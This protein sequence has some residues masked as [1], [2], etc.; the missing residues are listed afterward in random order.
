MFQVDGNFHEILETKKLTEKA[1]R[2]TAIK[3]AF[4]AP[5][6]LI[7]NPNQSRKRHEEH[8]FGAARRI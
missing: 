6:N 1:K 7:S 4:H 5:V 3:E 2:G 8:F